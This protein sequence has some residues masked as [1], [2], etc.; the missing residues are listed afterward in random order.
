MEYELIY[1]INNNYYYYYY[2]KKKVDN[3][4]PG[5]SESLTPYQSEVP[6]PTIS[7][8]RKKIKSY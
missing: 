1:H 2:Y 4:R 7:T 3:A 5:E 6:C 8:Q